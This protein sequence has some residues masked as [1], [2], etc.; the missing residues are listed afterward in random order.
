MHPSAATKPS[1]LPLVTVKQIGPPTELGQGT[2]LALERI[3][4]NDDRNVQRSWERC[5][6]KTSRSSADAVDIHVVL[7]NPEP[8]PAVGRYCIEFPSGLIDPGEDPVD[9]AIRELKE[10]TGYQVN[11]DD[12]RLH[13][14]PVCYEPGLTN[15]CCYV[16]QVTLPLHRPSAQEH[17]YASPK[18][19]LEPDEWSLQ[20]I[21]LPL[22]KD[23][24]V[25]LQQLE[26]THGLLIDSRV[27]A[28]AAGLAAYHSYAMPRN[29][30][31]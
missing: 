18:Q 5:I 23:M 3:T 12:I 30:I 4:Y 22:N 25:Q 29:D 6:R 8:E 13:K 9:T 26:E 20:R 15:S 7:L 28:Y 17:A 24:L 11:R 31:P 21:N 19:Q 2:W 14:R 16:A 27:H 1:L 10:E